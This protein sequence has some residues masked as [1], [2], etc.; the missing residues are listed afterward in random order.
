MATNQVFRVQLVD[1]AGNILPKPLIGEYDSLLELDG[2]TVIQDLKTS[3]S[4]WP[5]GKAHRDLQATAYL[6]AY[7]RETGKD[8]VFRFDVITKAKEPKIE[9]HCTTREDDDFYRLVELVKTAEAII[10]QGLFYP[11]EQSFFCRNCDYQTA[12]KSWHQKKR[13]CHP[14][15]RAA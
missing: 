15:A 9:Q 5:A 7:K 2:M 1:A 8:A 14:A 13:S 12:C 3:A 6:Y 10:Q 11:N 4:R